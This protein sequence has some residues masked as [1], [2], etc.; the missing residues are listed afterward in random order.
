MG[1]ASGQWLPPRRPSNFN[2][3]QAQALEFTGSDRDSKNY[4]EGV[5]CLALRSINERPP[6]N[7]P[8]L[9][10]CDG[11]TRRRRVVRQSLRHS[12]LSPA[13]K[14]PEKGRT[15]SGEGQDSKDPI[16][17]RQHRLT[18]LRDAARIRFDVTPEKWTL[19]GSSFSR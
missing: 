12:K 10:S 4:K 11:M 6:V 7:L 14:L 8:G 5:E 13:P 15:R 3:E 9:H 2:R 18:N 1:R 16:S 17:E 19:V